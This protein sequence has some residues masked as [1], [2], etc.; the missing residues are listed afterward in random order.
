MAEEVDAPLLQSA[1]DAV[2]ARFP[3]FAVELKRGLFW[4][5]LAP[6]RNRILVGPDS[7][8]P[9]QDYDVNARGTC[10]FRVRVAG[11]RIACEFHHSLTDGTGGLRFLK[12]LLVE[13]CRLTFRSSAGTSIPRPSEKNDDPDL[14]ALGGAPA[15]EEYEDAYHRYYREAIPAPDKIRPAFRLYSTPL[16]LH[17]YR[18]ICGQIPLTDALAEAKRFGVSLTEL[19][20]ATY[21][22]ALQTIWLSRTKAGVRAGAVFGA[23]P[24]LVVSVPVDMRRLLPSATNRNFSLFACVSQDM[25]LGRRDLAEIARR[26]HYQ[27]RFETDAKTM[28]RQLSRNVSA[29]GS[30]I[31]RVLP[32][33]LKTLVFRVLSRVFGEDLYTAGLSNLGAVSL[34]PEIEDQVERFDFIQM[35]A[36]N[37]PEV[38]I[39]SWRSILYISIGSLGESRELERLFFTR[40]RRLGLHVRIECNLSEE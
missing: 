16:P 32:L 20:V 12:N 4:H 1:L 6:C 11:R 21:I 22:D 35:L 36:K 37:K 38:G 13:Y 18:T 26:A 5:Y 2:I 17:R 34:P 7:A 27:L 19:L 30:M 10:L 29:S 40:L 9:S 31:F 23:R 14:Y 24:N 39:I 25:R 8:S 3:Y 28:G 33:P 15:P